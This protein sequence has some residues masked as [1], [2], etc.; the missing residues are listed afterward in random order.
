MQLLEV[1]TVCYAPITSSGVEL[2][3]HEGSA[4]RGPEAAR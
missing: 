2:F 4:L 3:L 1:I